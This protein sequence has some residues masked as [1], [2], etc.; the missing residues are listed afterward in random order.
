M[1]TAVFSA[2]KWKGWNVEY[3]MEFAK[4]LA[5]LETQK[6]SNRF[7]MSMLSGQGGKGGFDNPGAIMSAVGMS[8]PDQVAATKEIN[9]TANVEGLRDLW[10]NSFQDLNSKMLA[11]KLSPA[12]RQSAIGS[13]SGYMQHKLEGRFNKDAADAQAEALLPGYGMTG[14]E[15][16]ETRANKWQRGNAM[17]DL[18]KPQP[19][20]LGKYFLSPEMFKATSSDVTRRF[21]PQQKAYYDWAKSNPN[22]PD[23]AMVLKKLGVS[24]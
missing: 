7:L 15:S 11:G 21:S 19:I 17:L 14:Y 22:N 13:I 4:S 5:A 3:S 6:V 23:S 2:L 18:M 12:D 9:E 8:E 24:K 10:K 20:T 16:D 1:A